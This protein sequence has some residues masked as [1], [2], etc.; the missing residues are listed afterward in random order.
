MEREKESQGNPYKQH[1]LIMIMMCVCVGGC[2]SVC[3]FDKI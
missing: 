3:V 2:V 1:A